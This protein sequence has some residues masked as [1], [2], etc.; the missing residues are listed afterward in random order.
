MTRGIFLFAKYE[1]NDKLPWYSVRGSNRGAHWTY[2]RGSGVRCTR[3]R[4]SVQTVFESRFLEHIDKSV[5]LENEPKY[6]SQKD[7]VNIVSV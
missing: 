7:L 3:T 2:G 6:L 4:G 5:R 1:L